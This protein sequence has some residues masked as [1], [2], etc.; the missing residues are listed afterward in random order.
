MV[1]RFG[2]INCEYRYLSLRSSKRRPIFNKITR[3][4]LARI[5][6]LFNVSL[7]LESKFETPSGAENC[8]LSAKAVLSDPGGLQYQPLALL[9]LTSG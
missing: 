1:S 6:S 8:S 7:L 9:I 5:K 2:S 3:G 4:P